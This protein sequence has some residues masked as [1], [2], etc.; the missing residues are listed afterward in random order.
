MGQGPD[1]SPRAPPDYGL[2]GL[3][4]PNI[5]QG[6]GWITLVPAGL[7]QRS[8]SCLLPGFL[9]GSTTGYYFY[10]NSFAMM[11]FLIK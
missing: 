8:W 3:A 7:P 6:A 5:G 10:R 9:A 11:L 1:S 2:C 4:A